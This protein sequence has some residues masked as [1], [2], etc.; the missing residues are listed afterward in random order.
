VF[1]YTFDDVI[2]RPDMVRRTLVARLD[3]ARP[4]PPTGR[5]TA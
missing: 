5:A 4:D 2:R 1:E 3:A